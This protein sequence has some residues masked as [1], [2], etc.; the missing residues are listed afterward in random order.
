MSKT[1]VSLCFLFALIAAAS[2]FSDAA[3]QNPPEL[4]LSYAAGEIEM[5]TVGYLDKGEGPAVVFFHPGVD[6]RYWQWAI[7][8]VASSYRA[9]ALPFNQAVPPAFGFVAAS[10]NLTTVLEGIING[11]D[12]APPHLVAHSMGGR[13]A[14]ELAITRPDL[15]ASL[16]VIE[17][18]LAPD[19]ASLSRLR[20]AAAASDVT[21]PL[22]DVA[23]NQ[24]TLCRF[25]V[26][27][28]EPGFYDNAPSALLELLAPPP[29]AAAPPSLEVLWPEALPPICDALGELEMPILFVRGELT[30]APIQASL[31][32]YEG[33]LPAH[34]SKTISNSAHYPFV[35]NPEAFSEVLLEFLRDR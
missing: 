19:D 28:N 35:Y 26:F 14:L 34:E 13:L 23:E 25:H 20:S 15:I 8:E 5:L 6:A 16:T 30:P 29:G 4:D 27:I 11:L 31:D 22:P 3:A 9:I 10:F 21:C 1:K 17:P 7:D 2:A 33:C 32:A 12:V 24:K 18:A